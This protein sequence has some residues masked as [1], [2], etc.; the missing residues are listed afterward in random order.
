MPKR[1]TTGVTPRITLG[2]HEDAIADYAEAY[3]N[4][5]NAKS[6]LGRHEDAIADY[7]EAIRLKPDYAKA[8]NNRG[9]AN[10]FLN[11]IDEARQDFKTAIVLARNVHDETLAS[12]AEHALNKLSDE[13]GP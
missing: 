6:G 13:Q 11:R 5:G 1:T 2:R 9:K 7:D 12:D 3:Y 10:A 4:R 8:Y